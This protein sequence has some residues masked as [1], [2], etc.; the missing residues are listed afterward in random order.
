MGKDVE[1]IGHFYF[2]TLYRYDLEGLMKT[3]NVSKRTVIVP[4]GNQ[5]RF[6][7]ITSEKRYPLS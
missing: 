6:L 1:G 4:V 5:S 7:L 2:R 3:T